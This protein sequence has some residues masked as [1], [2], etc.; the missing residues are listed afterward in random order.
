MKTT[1]EGAVAL[2]AAAGTAGWLGY[3]A[4]VPHTTGG[5]TVFGSAPL[6]DEGLAPLVL[7]LV[8]SV[9]AVAAAGWRRVAPPATIGVAAVAGPTVLAFFTAPQ[10]DGDGLW[11][12]I[13][14]YFVVLGYAFTALARFTE[15]VSRKQPS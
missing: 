7:Y 3:V 13:F 8:V 11:G 9:I 2:V 15:R 14:L 6:T 4:L 12:L 1:H 10:G 5:D